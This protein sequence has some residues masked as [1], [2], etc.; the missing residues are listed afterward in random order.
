MTSLNAQKYIDNNREILCPRCGSNYVNILGVDVLT[1]FN[2]E[3][4]ITH[5][6]TQCQESFELRIVSGD[7]N[8]SAQMHFE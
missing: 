1:Q 6:C 4:H 8:T 7:V 5:G 2:T 3:V